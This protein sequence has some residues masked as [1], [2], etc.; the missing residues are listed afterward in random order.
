[1]AR[2]LYPDAG[3]ATRNRQAIVPAQAVINFAAEAELCPPIR[4]KRF[5]A[6]SKIKTPVTM[7]WLEPFIDHA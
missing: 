2:E 1:M 4:V 3:G 5:K 7:E 6:A